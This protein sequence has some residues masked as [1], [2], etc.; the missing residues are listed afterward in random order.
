MNWNNYFNEQI[1]KSNNYTLNNIN[2]FTGNQT[3]GFFNI[4]K[5]IVRN[6]NRF[7]KWKDP[8]K[9]Q[10]SLDE[11]KAERKKILVVNSIKQGNEIVRIAK[12]R[13]VSPHQV[14]REEEEQKA[15]EQKVKE[16]E[17]VKEA[18]KEQEGGRRQRKKAKFR[19]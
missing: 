12:E 13:G 7:S 8:E 2:D 4:G 15:K 10:K 9:F 6:N 11:S 18:V 19:V 1:N 17:V 5:S 16:Q 3:G 14:I